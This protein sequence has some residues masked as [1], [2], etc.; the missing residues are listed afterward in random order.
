MDTRKKE[1]EKE[2]DL[3]P[4]ER[5]PK[6]LAGSGM[7]SM[8]LAGNET[9]AWGSWFPCGNCLGSSWGGYGSGSERFW[10]KRMDTRKKEKEKEKDLAPG[11]RTP[12]VSGVVREP[13]DIAGVWSD[14]S[15]LMAL[16]Q[17]LGRFR[18]DVHGLGRFRNDVHGLGR[19]DHVVP[20]TDLD[21][22][23]GKGL[24]SKK[25]KEAAGAS[26]NVEAVG[27]NQTQ[28]L[29]T[30]LGTVN[31]EAGLPQG[32]ILPTE[33][34]V[35]NVGDQRD[36]DL[37]EQGETSHTEE[38]VGL[39]PTG[40]TVDDETGPDVE[41]AEPSIKDVLEAMKLMGAQMVTLT[42]VFTPLVNSFVGQLTQ[43][44]TVGNQ[45][46]SAWRS[47]PVQTSVAGSER[48]PSRPNGPCGTKSPGT[49]LAEPGN[50]TKPGGV[51]FRV[52]TATGAVGAVM[53]A[54]LSDFGRKGTRGQVASPW[55]ILCNRS[56]R[57][58]TSPSLYKYRPL[59]MDTRQKEKEKEK[60]KDLAPGE[61]T[62]KVSG[63]VCK[64][65]DIAG[66][67]SDESDLMALN[68]GLGRFMN[69]VHG[70]GRTDHGRDLYDQ[71]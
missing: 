5:T 12:K 31:T 34:Q 38:R 64:P 14:G 47:V 68:K 48:L 45:L 40:T 51:G 36:Q 11:E 56:A 63:V 30:Q 3:A 55:P 65:S 24:K 42:Q 59:W 1:K 9:K 67:W 57:A 32:P 58:V 6:A 44:G 25:G 20:G 23:K 49:I 28:V 70:L 8:A 53:G 54:V 27:V 29:P 69:D 43:L 66:V 41:V 46:T 10:A 62:P 26:G 7:M 52:G 17:G 15:D 22:G 18:N 21:R 33:V 60:E 13:S 2:K 71:D 35:E 39:N 16:N 19:T 4:G 50:E 61:R 37:G